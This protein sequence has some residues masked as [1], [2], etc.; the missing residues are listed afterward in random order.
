M[1][2]RDDVVTR[3][4]KEHQ[5]ELGNTLKRVNDYLTQA[6]ELPV[7]F[8]NQIF[9]TDNRLIICEVIRQLKEAGWRVDQKESLEGSEKIISYEIQ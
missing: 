3:L 9:G 5:A 8:D 6:K 1:I 4:A 7:V 2:R